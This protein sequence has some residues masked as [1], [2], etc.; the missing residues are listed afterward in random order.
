MAKA[1]RY[2]ISIKSFI[3]RAVEK[4]LLLGNTTHTLEIIE[5]G[6][7]FI[8]AKGGKFKHLRLSNTF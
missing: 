4:Y 5:A 6:A 1:E 8:T 7:F 2:L 3:V